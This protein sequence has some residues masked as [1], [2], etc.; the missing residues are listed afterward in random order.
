MFCRFFSLLLLLCLSVAQA[1][2]AVSVATATIQ[3]IEHYPQRHRSAHVIALREA[4][5]SARISAAVVSIQAETGNRIEYGQTLVELD[6]SDLELE[7]QRLQA[8]LKR[9]QANRELTLSQLDRAEELLR[10]RSISRDE[11]DQRRTA[12]DANNASV[13][14]QL[15]L[16]DSNQSSINKCVVTAPFSGQILQRQVQRGQWVSPGMALF[17]LLAPQ[18]VELESA[19]PLPWAEELTQAKN[20]IWTDALQQEYPVTLRLAL[21]RVDDLSQ[22][23][24]LRLRF[25][26]D[27]ALPG[28]R[29]TL[30][31]SSPH[32]L[33]PSRYLVQR[34]QNLG[35]LAL[36]ND[37][38]QFIAVPEAQEGRDSRHSLAADLRIITQDLD[39]LQSGQTVV[40]E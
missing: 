36:I 29:G 7:R 37:K 8:G 13:D 27:P 15:A 40:A 33:I 31:W 19:M 32:G 28:Q 10:T 22:Q 11:L 17:T 23:Q 2:E 20:L 38:I 1:Q 5:I 35:V 30:S 9:L 21:P 18:R 39:T 16:L 25:D 6:C 34:E 12:L 26:S 3:E 24:N 4:D 14:E